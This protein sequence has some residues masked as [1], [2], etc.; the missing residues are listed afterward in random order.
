MHLHH[1]VAGMVL[2][3]IGDELL[4]RRDIVGEMRRPLVEV[5]AFGA[6][7]VG[8]LVAF[9]IGPDLLEA[10]RRLA[11]RMARANSETPLSSRR[12]FL[13]RR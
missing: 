12:F 4:G 3:E 7:N 11:L 10:A 1:G 2:Q 6:R 5:H 9:R 8:D 13:A